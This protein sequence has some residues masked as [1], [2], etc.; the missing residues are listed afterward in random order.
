MN[1]I[2]YGPRGISRVVVRVGFGLALLCTGIAHAREL[3][4]FAQ[5][6]GQGFG[7]AWLESVG[8]VWGYVLPF[9]FILGGLSLTLRLFPRAGTWLA[10]IGLVSIPVGLMLKSA[11]SGLSLGETMPPAM[12]AW[13][14]VMVYMFAAKSAGCGC[15]T[16]CDSACAMPMAKASPVKPAPMVMKKPAAKKTTKK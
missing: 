1:C 4:S 7:I 2:P 15:G 8:Q 10:G 5:S 14:W 16:G 11:V 12:N 6:V 9:L 3:G 13:I